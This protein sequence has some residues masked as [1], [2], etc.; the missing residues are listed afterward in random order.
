MCVYIAG[1]TSHVDL[2]IARAHTL[3]RSLLALSAKYFFPY[4]HRLNMACDSLPGSR[5]TGRVFTH[6]LVPLNS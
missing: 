2:A 4:V 5:F 1:L 6:P 3:L